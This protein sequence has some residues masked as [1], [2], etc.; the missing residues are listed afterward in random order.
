MSL[1]PL[2][3]L[4]P[5]FHH[6]LPCSPDE[7]VARMQR[8]LASSEGRFV[9]AIAGHHVDVNLP[10]A[11]RRI[12]SP[13]LHLEF[14]EEDGRAVLHG[15]LAPVPGAWTCYALTLLSAVTVAAFAACFA[16][17]QLMLKQSPAVA[18]VAMTTAILFSVVLYRLSQMGQEATRP[19]MR[20]LR[21]FALTAIGIAGDDA[22]PGHP[23][24]AKMGGL[25]AVHVAGEPGRPSDHSRPGG[26]T[27]TSE[28]PENRK[29]A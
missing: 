7:A 16:G 26:D 27:A 6:E 11:D 22:E 5:R 1:H 24:A 29:N 21:D 23:E 17:V 10:A 8:G 9:G 12:W 18:L 4:R 3:P 13:C 25:P 14:R 19:E 28:P 2:P 15:L 20:R